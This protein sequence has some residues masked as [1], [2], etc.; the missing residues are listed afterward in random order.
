MRGRIIEFTMAV[1]AALTVGYIVLL[2]TPR[3]V[4]DGMKVLGQL[5]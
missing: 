5:F 4:H 2:S 3:I 1:T